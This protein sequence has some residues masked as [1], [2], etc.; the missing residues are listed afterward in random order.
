M[1]SKRR[2]SLCLN[3][4]LNVHIFSLMNENAL[5]KYHK[6]LNRTRSKVQIKQTDIWLNLIPSFS[7]KEPWA[8]QTWISRTDLLVKLLQVFWHHA[9]GISLGTKTCNEFYIS[10]KNW[11]KTK[12]FFP[13]VKTKDTFNFVVSLF[14]GFS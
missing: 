1:W 4:S 6:R 10:E 2:Y 9:I 3:L 11:T 5:K 12:E 13:K 8:I 14:E 7:V